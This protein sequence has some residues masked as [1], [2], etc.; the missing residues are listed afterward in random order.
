MFNEIIPTIFK[1]DEKDFNAIKI[2]YD[3]CKLFSKAE[4][5][6]DVELVTLKVEKWFDKIIPIILENVQYVTKSPNFTHYEYKDELYI[7]NHTCEL[8]DFKTIEDLIDFL[9]SEKFYEIVIFYI[10][11][12]I[13]LEKMEKNWILRFGRI[14]NKE[15]KRDKKINYLDHSE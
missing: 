9:K 5:R 11:C 15:I 13:D 14:E 10:V 4:E 7:T 3:N 8:S 2:L 12:H 1:V 6:Y